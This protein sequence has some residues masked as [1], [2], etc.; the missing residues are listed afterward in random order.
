VT[1]NDLLEIQVC[2]ILF[3]LIK[4]YTIQKDIFFADKICFVRLLKRVISSSDCLTG[5][6][7]NIKTLAVVMFC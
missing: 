1:H 5:I 7:F 3:L 2:L 6:F 4:G